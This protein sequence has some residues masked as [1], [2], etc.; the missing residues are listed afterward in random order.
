MMVGSAGR[1][2]RQLLRGLMAGTLLL[3]STAA[4]GQEPS[5]GVGTQG[6]GVLA[7]AY[8]ALRI[9]D[10]DAAVQCFERVLELTPARTDVRKNLAY[11][12]FKIG[13]NELARR[14]FAEVVKR[15]SSDEASALELAYLD[16]EAPDPQVKGEAFR[17]FRHLRQARDPA[18]R[19]HATEAYA[20]ADAALAERMKLWGE[21][22]RQEPE[23]NLMSEKYAR[24][25]E[26]RGLVDL[27]EQYYRGAASKET[28]GNL[29]A[30]ARL[31]R[32]AGRISEADAEEAEVLGGANPFLAEEVRESVAKRRGELVPASHLPAIAPNVAP[33][34]YA[35]VGASDGP[36]AA[37]MSAGGFTK[38]EGR[39]A[40]L[41]IVRPEAAGV[42]RDWR[43]MAEAGAFVV[44]Q[45]PS[46]A[47]A[48]FGFQ[49]RNDSIT[50]RVEL[51][52]HYR[53]QT[54][55]WEDSAR[56]ARVVVPT[57]A[58]VFSR[59]RWSGAALIAGY[60]VGKG[61]VLWVATGPGKKGFE[62]F[63]YLLLALRDLGLRSAVRGRDLQVLF[64]WSYRTRA[65]PEYLARQWRKMGVGTVH[66][67]AWYFFERDKGLD[68]ALTL[69]IDAAH[70]NGI[71]V[72]AWFQFPHVSNAFWNEHP[73]W[74]E[75]NALLQD[76]EIYWRKNMN[77]GNPGAFKAIANGVTDMV[78]RF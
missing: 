27:A 77:L 17:L 61:G 68:S 71:I 51:D 44:L 54:I 55:L 70:R 66:V 41:L 38:A 63:P 4:I 10:Y 18:I 47:A 14:Q 53:E 26:E 50:A 5:H 74:R 56:L 57:R 73:E 7:K 33:T 2:Q 13:R 8:A 34:G 52:V 45:G 25:A 36:W 32:A 23:N 67:S 3:G 21:A 29:L 9:R 6:Y 58:T 46:A 11:T 72:Y 59:E 12:Y 42:K 39:S 48:A 15:D 65:D 30:A 69:L 37:I 60:R 28:M 64:D 31:A 62:R 1:G 24:A 76:A 35:I 75:K 43:A 49:A 40:N 19:A 16:F 20:N 22:M 78:T